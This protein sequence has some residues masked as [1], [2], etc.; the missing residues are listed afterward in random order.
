MSRPAVFLDRDGTLIKD[1]RYIARPEDVALLPGAAEAVRGLNEAGWPVI[2][3]TNQS[4]IARR[5]FTVD[6]YMRVQD[7]T[8]AEL[9]RVGAHLDASYMCPHHPD[10]TGPC[11]CRKPGTLLYR[12]AATTHNLD[13]SR[14]WFIGD[15]IRDVLPA[16]E[17]GGRG[18]LVPSEETP[19]ADLERGRKEFVVVPSLDDAVSRILASAR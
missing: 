5:Y 8:A 12:Q 13:V 18:I 14:S 19:P 15:R 7:F 16:L 6:D 11:E 9:V 2:V 3:V 4:G 10:F 17:L 1:A